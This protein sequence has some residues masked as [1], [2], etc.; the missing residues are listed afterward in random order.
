MVTYV[1]MAHSE[2]FFHG[3]SALKTV[4]W[5]GDIGSLGGEKLGLLPYKILKS[6]I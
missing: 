4:F 3:A 6:T 1:I 5:S 2:F